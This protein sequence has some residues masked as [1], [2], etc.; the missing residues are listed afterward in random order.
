MTAAET[1]EA[2]RAY[3]RGL[4]WDGTMRV[5][6]FARVVLRSPSNRARDYAAGFLLDAVA[7]AFVPG[8]KVG[9]V[10]TL[11]GPQGTGKSH[12]LR[13]LAGDGYADVTAR[14]LLRPPGAWVIEAQD[15]E[16]MGDAARKGFL[17]ATEDTH[18]PPLARTTTREPRAYVIAVTT[19]D[20]AWTRGS[21]R[22]AVV[23]ITEP[24][25]VALLTTWR[26]QLWAEAVHLHRLSGGA[27]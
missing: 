9:P 25:N 22:I 5:R 12:A 14:Y 8:C 21:R 1:I 18:R 3:L 27:T 13:V 4:A 10:L 24:I 15:I 7:R 17:L 16:T 23:P 19:N 26:D 6:D 20:A 2:R 11:C